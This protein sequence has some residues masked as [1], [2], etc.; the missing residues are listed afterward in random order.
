MSQSSLNAPYLSVFGWKNFTWLLINSLNLFCTVVGALLLVSPLLRWASL[1][2]SV[3]DA[4]SY[5]EIAAFI[6]LVL[7]VGLLLF[8]SRVWIVAVTLL[9]SILTVVSAVNV[10]SGASSCGYWGAYSPPSEIML[11]IDLLILAWGKLLITKCSFRNQP[12]PL[13]AT[14]GRFFCVLFLAAVGLL[15]C[16]WWSLGAMSSTLLGRNVYVDV[17]KYKRVEVGTGTFRESRHVVLSNLSPLS[18]LRLVGYRSSCSCV[19]LKDFPVVVGPLASVTLPL[20][21]E[22]ATPDDEQ[23]AFVRPI[24][25]MLTAADGSKDGLSFSIAVA[26]KGTN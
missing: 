5:L 2:G 13:L 4:A 22:G 1:D 15:S 26:F 16:W 24:R 18:T 11:V 23:K 8:R 14:S 3:S 25:V 20:Y 21:F 6:E 9:F 17:S 7:G 19:Y 12:L 10:Y